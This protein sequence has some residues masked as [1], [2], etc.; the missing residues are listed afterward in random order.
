MTTE[1]VVEVHPLLGRAATATF[2]G[3]H[4]YR[5]ALTRRWAVGA[6]MV[7]LMCN[8]STADEQHEDPTVRRCLDFARRNGFAALT[9]VNLFALRATDPGE[10]ACHPDPV[11]PLNDQFFC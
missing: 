1:Y 8:P 7:F 9:V 6:A 2:D 10:L 4:A 5:Y 3:A 11:G